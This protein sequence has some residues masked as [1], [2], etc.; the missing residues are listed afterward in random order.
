M[1][2]LA[3]PNHMKPTSTRSALNDLRDLLRGLQREHPTA[4]PHTLACL[5]MALWGVEVSGA[6]VKQL[7][8]RMRER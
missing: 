6:R 5:V 4:H 3:P 2:S 8:E 7:I 1:A